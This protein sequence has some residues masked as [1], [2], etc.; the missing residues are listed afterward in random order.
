MPFEQGG[1][2]RNWC[3]DIEGGRGEEEGLKHPLSGGDGSHHGCDLRHAASCHLFHDI[4]TRSM[5]AART[6]TT[7]GQGKQ[8]EG[9]L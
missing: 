2:E 6:S 9:V 8:Q 1:L 3:A 7:W 5:L 4:G